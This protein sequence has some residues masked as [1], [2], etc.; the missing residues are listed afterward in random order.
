[1][2]RRCL[3]GLFWWRPLLR[4]RRA[5]LRVLRARQYFRPRVLGN[6]RD[7]MM[8]RMSACGIRGYAKGKGKKGKKGK[9][10]VSEGSDGDDALGDVDNELIDDL[11]EKVDAIYNDVVNEISILRVGRANPE[12]LSN[13]KIRDIPLTDIASI[14]VKDARTLGIAPRD[15]QD[16]SNIDRQLRATDATGFVPKVENGVVFVSLPRA[17]KELKTTL[18]KQLSS[19]SEKGKVNIRKA[20]QDVLGKLKK[21]KKSLPKDVSFKLEKD[22]QSICDDITKKIDST[23]KS[24]EKEI[25]NQ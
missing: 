23:A 25:E 8:W 2:R 20:R 22:L 1:M 17:T 12:M 14:F 15:A 5:P 7:L 10:I 6:R 13:V 4:F 24:K 19:F 21:L 11:Q 3:V 9:Q 16:V 18:L